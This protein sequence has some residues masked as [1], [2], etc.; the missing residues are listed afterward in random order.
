MEPTKHSNIINV[1]FQVKTIFRDSEKKVLY[2]IEYDVYVI[3]RT[4]PV[5]KTNEPTT[6]THTPSIIKSTITP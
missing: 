2:D 6:P 1:I 5:I 3:A 4:K